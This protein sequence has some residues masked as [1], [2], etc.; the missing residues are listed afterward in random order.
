MVRIVDASVAFKWFVPEDGSDLALAILD[1]PERLVAPDIILSEVA[2][3]LWVRLRK[4]ELDGA[5]STVVRDAVASLKR[6][7]DEKVPAPEL[8]PRAVELAFALNHPVYDC[9]YLALAEREQ[10][11]LV[12][13]DKRLVETARK[14]G[15]GPL[16]QVLA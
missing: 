13:A 2:N 1:G 6:M 12:S 16:A 4:L 5:P 10:A 7:L 9:L 15:Y 3:A 14:G 11:V 8:L